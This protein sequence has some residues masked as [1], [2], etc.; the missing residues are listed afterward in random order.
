MF[1]YISI[2]SL[3]FDRVEFSFSFVILEKISFFN[4]NIPVNFTVC[5]RTCLYL[6]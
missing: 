3:K 2:M 6:F 1:T 5:F 4:F